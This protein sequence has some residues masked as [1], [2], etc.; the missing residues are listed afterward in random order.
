[1]ATG[2]V[3]AVVLVTVVALALNALYPPDLHRLAPTVTVTDRDGRVLRGFLSPDET[4]RLPTT[5]ADVDP[6]YL[7][8]LMAFEDSRFRWHP[9][10]DPLAVVRATGQMLWHGAVVSGASTLSMQAARLLEPRPRTLPSKLIEMARALQLTAHLGRDGVLS[11]YLTLAPFG[12]NLEGVRAASLAWWG[13]APRRLTP[14]QAALLVAL[15]QTPAAL[16]P[17][18]HPEAARAARA[19]V[20]RRMVG[21]GVLTAAQAREAEAEPLPAVRQPMPFL[22]AHLAR[23]LADDRAPGDSAVIRTTLDAPLQG[24]VEALVRAHAMALGD[25]VSVAALVVE[26][27]T[28]AARAWVGSPGLL[29]TARRG[30]VDMTRAPRS[31]GSA[32]KPLIYGMAFEDGLLHPLT[33]I[34]DRPMAF[35]QGYTPAN[36]GFAHHG[37]VTAAEALRRSLNVPAVAVLDRVGPLRFAARLTT[38]GVTP[39]RR[40]GLGRPGLPL[41]LGG[42]GVTLEEL[43]GLYAA[44]A[45]DGTRRTVW[46]RADTPPPAATARVLSPGAAWQVRAILAQAPPAA[47][48]APDDATRGGRTV[49][50]KTGTSYGFRD[51]WAVGLDGDHVIGVWVG[52]ADGTPVPGHLGRDTAAPLM[53]ALFDL[54]PPP[55]HPVPGPAPA[56]LL[57]ALRTADLPPP[58]R[59]LAP[60]DGGGRTAGS[61]DGAGVDP[62]RLRF[63]PDGA[64]LDWDQAARGLVLEAAGGQRPYA[65]LVNGRPLETAPWHRGAQWQPDGRGAAR[66]TVVDSTGR[67][68]SAAVWLE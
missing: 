56:G 12:G 39:R 46:A 42:L 40:G 57:G 55:R 43:T 63:P 35:G 23:R 59:R 36:F 34:D 58:L 49:A 21:A 13:K 32:L 14:G 5:P 44:L 17:D 51:A 68:A 8:M 16:R 20:L 10:V 41:A 52:R 6:L 28:G 25:R 48:F 67:A 60:P 31:P 37:R 27:D 9:G 24:R 2:S 22:A 54:L 47:G 1:M 30:A 18:R 66:V 38:A 29:D 62:L 3:L 11:A 15:P 33:E 50:F 26:A 65:W 53:R 64:T 19:K 7:A 61:A 45:T 4:W